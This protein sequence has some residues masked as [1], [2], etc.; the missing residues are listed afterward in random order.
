M[1]LVRSSPDIETY[2]SAIRTAN[3]NRTV[4]FENLWTI[5]PPGD[6]VY[7][8]PFMKESQI[9]IVKEC[10]T[11]ATDVS[12]SGRTNKDARKVWDLHCWSYDWDGKHF[13]RVPVMFRFE[14]F[15]GAKVIN[16]LHCHPLR[17]RFPAGDPNSERDKFEADL[18]ERGKLFRKY[19]A[20][21]TGEQM[22]YYEG[23]TIS[24][25]SGFQ[26][27]KNKSKQVRTSGNFVIVTT[28][29]VQDSNY[30]R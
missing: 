21:T 1:E 27:L 12:D 23:D 17:Y 2:L 18:I 24:H 10:G 6:L 8:M 7:A 20:R 28:F 5:F 11:H 4:H 13:T 3:T 22:I 15:T 19:C 25:G 16:T 30:D 14:E 26:R 29:D 9:F